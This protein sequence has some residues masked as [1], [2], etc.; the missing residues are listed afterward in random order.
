V[1]SED[2]TQVVRLRRDELGPPCIEVAWGCVRSG[3]PARS[4]PPEWD[5]VVGHR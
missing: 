2:R 5:S 1:V 4:P 3:V